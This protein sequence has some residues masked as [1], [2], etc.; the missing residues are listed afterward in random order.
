MFR[1][2]WIFILLL[3]APLTSHAATLSLDGTGRLIGA[4]GVAVGDDLYDVRFREGTFADVFGQPAGDIMSFTLANQ[5]SQALLA[6]V[7]VNSIEGN[8]DSDPER[9]LGC[10]SDFLCGILSPVRR[11]PN[12]PGDDIVVGTRTLNF[13][14][15]SGNPDTQQSFTLDVTEST[16]DFTF[17]NDQV[18][19]EWSPS[20]AVTVP[21]PAALPLLASALLACA[22]CR[23]R[24]ARR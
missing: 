16:E 24:R 5:L 13:D 2:F 6:Q 10:E 7:L 20:A 14:P 8:F 19:A 1:T 12:P 11:T 9:T 17:T 3:G 21:I 4:F 22:G 23:R 18:W 15:L